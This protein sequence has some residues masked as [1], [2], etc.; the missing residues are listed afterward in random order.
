MKAA[1]ISRASNDETAMQQGQESLPPDTARSV[2]FY[3]LAAFR[4]HYG[5][6][7]QISPD[8]PPRPSPTWIPPLTQF[9]SFSG[10]RPGVRLGTKFYTISHLK[11]DNYLYRLLANTCSEG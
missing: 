9:G 4:R 1:I 6:T 7:Y 10:S 3:G 11:A 2:V 8:V 5:P